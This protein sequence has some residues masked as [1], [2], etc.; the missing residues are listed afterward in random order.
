M[1]SEDEDDYEDEDD[2]DDDDVDEIDGMVRLFSKFSLFCFFLPR[3][4]S[5]RRIPM[6]TYR[7]CD[8]GL[9]VEEEGDVLVAH[10]QQT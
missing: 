7:Q 10:R 4:L 9:V 6:R 1:L 8:E 5:L 2:D 3:Y